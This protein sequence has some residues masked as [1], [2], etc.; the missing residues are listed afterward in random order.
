[1]ST[2]FP[3]LTLP[4]LTLDDVARELGRSRDWLARHHGDDVSLPGFP[5]P[6]HERGGLVW[7][8]PAVWAWLDRDLPDHLRAHAAAYRAALA[9]AVERPDADD[10]AHW[11]DVL[12][13]KFG[14]AA[15]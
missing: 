3:A 4:A 9:A 12:N 7:S 5:A 2:S 8:A 10:T 11:R 14:G 6:I 15:A 13:R 1:M